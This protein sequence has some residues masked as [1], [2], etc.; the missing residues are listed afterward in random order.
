M[1]LDHRPK[2]EVAQL[3]SAKTNGATPL[4]LACRN[5]HM[6][7]VEYLVEKCAANVEQPGKERFYSGQD[8]RNGRFKNG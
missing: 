6:D 7:V 2:D 3:V 8:T 5:G 1:F 4:V